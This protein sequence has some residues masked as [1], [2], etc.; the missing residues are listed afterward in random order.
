AAWSTKNHP[1]EMKV[2]FAI[3]EFGGVQL[4]PGNFILSVGEKGAAW[5]RISFKGTS[6]AA[7]MP[8]K[9]NNPVTKAAK[10]AMRIEKY[11]TPIDTKYLKFLAKGF[12]A[13]F[14]Q[15]ILLSNKFLLPIAL[16][17]LFKTNPS[18]ARGLH[19]L[20]RMTIAPTR[21]ESGI[22]TNV[23]PSHS[24]IDV[25][26]R[27][28]PGQNYEYIISHLKKAIGK[29]LAKEA[30]FKQLTEEEGIITFGNESPTKSE[31]VSAMAQALNEIFPNST[32]IPTIAYGATD[33]RFIRELG[34]NGYGFSLIDPVLT[35]DDLLK[36]PHG[37][38]ERVS[39][40]CIELTLD[41]YYK[42]ARIFLMEKN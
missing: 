10:A 9:I 7:S 20:S 41:I 11:K 32:L 35:L 38:N 4:S 12:G 21:I 37:T 27:M 23:I 13:S 19:S 29:K 22:K 28:L 25:D 30:D 3:S 33:L 18:M 36:L 17:Q 14:F 26:I 24:F 6:G 5:I 31:F 40:K 39:L 15:R 16:K 34:G 1:K 8:Y 42:L 2:D